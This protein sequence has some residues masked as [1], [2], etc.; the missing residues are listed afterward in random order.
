MIKIAYLYSDIHLDKEIISNIS[1]EL[2]IEIFAASIDVYRTEE[3]KKLIL[4]LEEKYFDIV[5]SRG[6]IIDKLKEIN[7]SI[8]F[9]PIVFSATETMS[10]LNKIRNKTNLS[11]TN[12][13]K[14]IGLVS[15]SH[16]QINEKIFSETYDIEIKNFALESDHPAL[17]K[18]TLKKIIDEN[19]DIIACNK[20]I[21]PFAEEMGL[22]TFF[23]PVQEPDFFKEGF[24]YAKNIA[25]ANLEMK[26]KKKELETLIDYSFHPVMTLDEQGNILICNSAVCKIF[27]LPKTEIIGSQICNLI[28]ELNKSEIDTILNTGANI[29]GRIIDIGH[30][31]IVLNINPVIQNTDSGTAVANFIL[32]N[33]KNS[34]E[35][36]S[37]TPK[38]ANN[39]ARYDFSNIKG[40]SPAIIETKRLAAQ[41][42]RYDSNIL[43]FGET[44]TGKEV[45]A[46]S[47]HNNSLRNNGPFVALNCGAIPLHLLESELFGYVEGAF[48][49]ASKKGKKGL[50]E[51]AD[52]GTI[53]LDEISEMD[54]NA[55][56]RLLRVLE[57]RSFT[58]VG[59][60]EV[61]HVNIRIIAASNKNLMDL[62]EQDKFRE[63]LFYRLNVLT[64]F[65]PPL[66]NRDSDAILLT[67]HFLQI[68]GETYNKIIQLDEQA[69]KLLLDFEWKGNIRQ[70]RNFC[71]RLIVVADRNIISA[72]FLKKQIQDVYMFKSRKV[73]TEKNIEPEVQSNLLF[74]DEKDKIIAALTR[75]NG[76]RKSAADVLGISLTTL[77]RKMKKYDLYNQTLNSNL[78]EAFYE[79]DKTVIN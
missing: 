70:L 11:K 68:F 62:V 3:I 31:V 54:I 13:I 9:L 79:A 28:P 42:A 37:K 58:R 57:E 18:T 46:Q 67:E 50:I 6:R 56:L 45:F 40:E 64:L 8:P 7:C 59:S 41:F 21:Q 63:D 72:A 22:P 30:A 10:I 32:L 4:E 55:Q 25:L 23:E 44:G 27:R 34:I 35:N 60:N 17:I 43:I 78:T 75:F 49:G 2:E 71:E 38:N 1:K 61:K 76:N 15:S 26:K 51:I 47:I 14:K 5:I 16:L 39:S 20:K 69:K 73:Q 36:S 33:D 74:S 19:F 77:W 48:T 52:K 24:R 53:F 66:R 12:N 29:F 65:I